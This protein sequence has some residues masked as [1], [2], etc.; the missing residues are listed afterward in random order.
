MFKLG[1]LFIELNWPVL[2]HRIATQIPSGRGDT[3]L[4]GDSIP[5]ET[6]WPCVALSLEREVDNRIPRVESNIRWWC[7]WWWTRLHTAGKQAAFGSIPQKIQI[8]EFHP[9]YGNKMT[10]LASSLTKVT[11]Q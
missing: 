2:V 9:D 4:K 5:F 10:D 7:W 3:L 11:D 8:V 6:S 1:L